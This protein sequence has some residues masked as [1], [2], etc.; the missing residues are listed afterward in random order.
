ME[1]S[2]LLNCLAI[3]SEA[4]RPRA[5]ANIVMFIENI[6]CRIKMTDSSVEEGS[7]QI[8]AECLK[9]VLQIEPYLLKKDIQS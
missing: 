6:T 9:N 2:V 1:F 4:S 7:L 8:T 5:F 3:G